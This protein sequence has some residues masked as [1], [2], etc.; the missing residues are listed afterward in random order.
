VEKEGLR[1]GEMNATLLQKIE[2]LTLY[3][4]EQ[5]RRADSLRTRLRDHRRTTSGALQRLRR[6]HDRLRTRLDAQRRLL[7]QL[8]QESGLER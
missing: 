4:I 7:K 1:L 3:A 5:D 6:E 8:A 2:E